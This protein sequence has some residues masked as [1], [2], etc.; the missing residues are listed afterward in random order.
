MEKDKQRKWVHG[1]FWVV[2]N[3]FSWPL[4]L[5]TGM[6]AGWL[7]WEAYDVMYIPFLADESNRMLITFI[8]LG[9]GWGV[10]IGFLQQILLKQRFNLDR[11]SWIVATCLGMALYLSFSQVELIAYDIRE[12]QPFSRG[13]GIL[14]SFVSSALLGTAQWVILRHTVKRAG[15]WILAT[16]I[17]LS[18]SPMVLNL[19][20]FGPAWENG[21]NYLVYSL[22]ASLRTGFMYGLITWIAVSMISPP[23]AKT[24]ENQP[25]L[26]N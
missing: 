3:T 6:A 4:S 12:L 11:R 7:A 9:V 15:L 23:S 18:V 16:V 24:L 8:L 2:A 13:L 10:A 20:H 14:A 19:F 1:L 25:G 21:R 26:V 5:W 22:F 17:A